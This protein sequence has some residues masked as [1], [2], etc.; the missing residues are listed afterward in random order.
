MQSRTSSLRP[1]L[2]RL[3]SDRYVI[4]C[5][6]LIV[7]WLGAWLLSFPNIYGWLTDD[8]FQFSRV[9]QY[10]LGGPNLIDIQWFHAFDWFIVLLPWIFHWNVPSHMIPQA[11]ERTG[12]FRALILYVMVLH[13]VLLAMLAYFIRQLCSNTIVCAGA[14]LL[15][16]TSPTFV[17]YTDL[18]DSRYL[19]LLAGVPALSILLLGRK[20]I[21]QPVRWPV[22]LRIHLPG[23]LIGLGQ[24]IHYTLLYF[25]GPIA[26]VYFLASFVE[27]RSRHVLIKLAFFTAGLLLWFVPVQLLSLEFHPFEGSMLGTLFGQVTSLGS[28]Y[29]QI[30]DNAS[31]LH[32]FIE[33]MGIP[34]MAAVTAGFALLVQ[35]SNA[36]RIHQPLQRLSD[37]RLDRHH[38]DLHLD[39][40]VGPI[41]P[42]SLGLSDFLH[43]L[44]TG[45][46]RRR[47]Q[48]AARRPEYA[49]RRPWRH[50]ASSPT[51]RRFFA[52]PRFSSPRKGSG[53]P[54]TLP[55]S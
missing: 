5:T 16:M 48:A 32:F 49:G 3:R 47:R 18:I 36:A 42:P 13:A 29:D 33:E 45:R 8:I 35:R 26:L 39:D 10:E 28:H 53:A 6:V 25:A 2:N 14:L 21:F 46:D 54:S 9:K 40:P 24:S 1:L 31:W 4:T 22:L 44:R 15:F 43:D 34:M 23:F 41:L 38:D 55:T 37:D 30:A 17:F 52:R 27:Q 19:G 7:V 20:Q 11:W 51:C 50:S 12:E